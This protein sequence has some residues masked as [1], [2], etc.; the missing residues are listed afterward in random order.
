MQKSNAGRNR[1]VSLRQ[2]A[3]S[4][5][6]IKRP[7][8]FFG[9]LLS[10]GDLTAE[11]NYHR[12]KQRRHNRSF[13]GVGVLHGLKVTSAKDKAG[14]TVVIEPGVA[15]D[16]EGN[17]IHL[18]TSMTFRLPKSPTA[19]EVGIRFSE[20]PSDPVPRVSDAE[21]SGSQPS[22]VEEGCE[23]I[24][25]LGPMSAGSR[26]NAG[27][28]GASLDFLPL[29]LLVRTKSVWKVNKKFKVPRAH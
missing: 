11:Q 21:S 20:R 19:I 25:N 29:A 13:H 27:E 6:P 3:Y 15:I 8:Y 7:N 14:W 5:N 17:E 2:A 24:L 18:C 4:A 12:E 28:C 26:A 9:K 22:R 10:A 23:V 16:P 1:D